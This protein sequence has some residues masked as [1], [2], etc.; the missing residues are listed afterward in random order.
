MCVYSKLH[1]HHIRRPGDRLPRNHL[2][3]IFGP[4]NLRPLL[5]QISLSGLSGVLSP[6]YSE[7]ID[8]KRWHAATSAAAVRRTDNLHIIITICWDDPLVQWSVG[9]GCSGRGWW[10]AGRAGCV[11]V[12]PGAGRR[13]SI[14]CGVSQRAQ[15]GAFRFVLTFLYFRCIFDVL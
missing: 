3:I 14:A 4:N 1:I 15:P 7:H 13:G 9:P 12:V 2:A 6:R 10:G 8:A 5:H 11:G